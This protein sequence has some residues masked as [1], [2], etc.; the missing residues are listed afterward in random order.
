MDLQSIAQE[1]W[2]VSPLL[3]AMKITAGDPEPV[4][5]FPHVRYLSSKIREAVASAGRLIVSMPPQ[6]GKPVKTKE[7]VVLGSGERKELGQIVVGD[8]VITHLGRPRK[9]LRVLEQGELD[10]VKITTECGR[11]VTAALDHPFLTTEGW[12]VAGELKEGSYLGDHLTNLQHWETADE[13][14][15]LE[16]ARMSG[17]FVGDGCCVSGTASVT[18]SNREQDQ[19][20]R[21][22]AE[23]L[24][25]GIRLE[26]RPC[27]P[28]FWALHF[29][30][31][32]RPWLREFGLE[33]H[34]SFDKRVP[35]Q[36]MK[37]SNEVVAN[38]LGAYFACDGSINRKG[39][40]RPD[41]TAEFYSVNKELLQDTQH[42]L[43]RLGIQSRLSPK[44]GLYKGAV[45]KSWR[46]SIW[47]RENVTRFIDRVPVYHSVKKARM[48]EWRAPRVAFDGLYLTDRIVSI[49]PCRAVCRCLEVEEDHTFLVSD[50]IVHNSTMG[51]LWT[52]TWFLEL[53]PHRNVILAGYNHDF[54]KKWGKR[55]RK[56]INNNQAHFRVRLEEGSE[57][58]DRWETNAGGGM[59]CSGVGGGISGNPAHLL[60]MDDIIKGHKD[61]SSYLKRQEA[62]DWFWTEA[63]TRI[64]DT[65][66]IL[67]FMTRWNE[68]DIAGRF[69][70][71]N[72]FGFQ[73]INMPAVWDEEA[74]SQGSCPIGRKIGDVLC[75]QLHSEKSV[76]LLMDTEEIKEHWVSLY[77]GR[78]GSAGADGNVYKKT[79]DKKL[80]VREVS[81][82]P[83]KKLFWSLDFNVD[84]MSSVIGQYSGG[85]AI[86]PL[87]EDQVARIEVLDELVLPESSTRE[88]TLE[89]IDRYMEMVA[90]WGYVNVEIHG[91]P[92]AK[93]KHSS[94]VA[95]TDYDII[96]ALLRE[97]GIPHT[98][99]I[100]SK[101]PPIKDR[102]NGVNLMMETAS[103]NR[104]TFIH[105]RCEKLIR[106]LLN[107]KWK[108][109]ANGNTTGQIDKSEPSLTHVSDAYGYFVAMR[110]S[111]GHRIAHTPGLMQ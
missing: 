12:K 80:N 31:A 83:R 96:R 50:L 8:T 33:G 58:A 25:F 94:Q 98:L 17:Y 19:D 1:G 28:N 67:L 42:L 65:T 3:T 46:L 56:V 77:Q 43:L 49:E 106:D 27:K 101:A 75:P 97:A 66:A 36:V 41:P 34:G 62:W 100:A 26:Q 84:P 39:D 103:G 85:L 95:G 108:K 69:L 37:G 63:N 32:A 89:F 52:P 79:F 73:V 9:V 30:D 76:K 55:V 16:A 61:A 48:S 91:D 68:D 57:Q 92:A 44:N 22:C 104:R 88:M 45:H 40:T 11:E 74:E 14:V 78:P 38:F 20:V 24:G 4:R 10:C 111:R 90:P 51:S 87:A 29:R 54:A 102:T 72:T 5:P 15:S 93:A 21:A 18:L 81:Y 60:I 109:D 99:N 23:V 86:D 71:N 13:Q 35:V 7:L 70:K 107:V 47:G 2:R 105:P 6:Y 59:L 64:H 53:Y 82:D 110:F